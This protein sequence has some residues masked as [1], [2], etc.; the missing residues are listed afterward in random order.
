M[1]DLPKPISGIEFLAQADEEHERWLKG[2]WGCWHY[3][4]ASHVLVKTESGR[5]VYEVDLDRVTSPR[6]LIDWLDHLS[7][8]G[9]PDEDLGSLL[10]ALNAKVGLRGLL[11]QVVHAPRPRRETLAPIRR[12]TRCKTE[13][14]KLHEHHYAPK[15]AFE[16]ADDWGT[17][18]LCQHCHRRWHEV[19]T[20]DV[21]LREMWSAFLRFFRWTKA[22]KR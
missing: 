11:P 7:G 22:W 21:H 20:P 18:L 14:G 5:W 9:W 3:E 19:M 12:C 10:R 16:D 2:P 4:A 6:E 13:T 8:K 1:S 15:Y 17:I